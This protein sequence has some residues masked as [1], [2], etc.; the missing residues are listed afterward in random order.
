MI[1][2]FLRHLNN[3]KHLKYLYYY[4]SL[5]LSHDDGRVARFYVLVVNVRES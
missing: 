2:I 3:P 4:I 1:Y 5:S